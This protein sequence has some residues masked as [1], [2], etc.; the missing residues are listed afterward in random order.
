ML[1]STL[2][3][4]SAFFSFASAAIRFLTQDDESGSVFHLEQDPDKHYFLPGIPTREVDIIGQASDAHDRFGVATSIRVSSSPL[5]RQFLDAQFN[6]FKQIDDVWSDKFM[7]TLFIGFEKEVNAFFDDS[8]KEWLLENGVRNLYI[9]RGIEKPTFKKANDLA[10]REVSDVP[11]HGPWLIR[12]KRHNRNRIRAYPVYGLVEDDHDAF[13]TGVLPDPIHG[14]YVPTNFTLESNPGA[15]YIPVPSRLSAWSGADLPLAGLRFAVK[16]IFDVQGL[17]TGAGSAAYLQTYKKAETTAPSVQRL[18]DLGATLVGKTRTSQFAHGAQPWEYVDFEY[19]RNPR[20]DGYLT[21]GASSSGSACAIAAYDWIDFT[22]GSDT[23]GSIRKPAAL[24]GAFGLRPSHGTL[25]LDG[26]LP[27]SEEMDTIGFFTRDPMIFE[28]IGRNWYA[29]SDV[30]NRSPTIRLPKHLLYP[31][32]H[33]PLA[34]EDAQILI[35]KFKHL[36]RKHLN[37]VTKPMDM[38]ETLAPHFPSKSFEKFQ[39]VSNSLAEWR[40][41][42]DVGKPLFRAYAN[43]FGPENILDLELDPVPSKMFRKGKKLTQSD[44]VEALV[45][46][47]K[48]ATAMDEEVFLPNSKACADSLFMY[49]AGTGGKPSF[50]H[51]ELNE[52]EGATQFVLTS[53]PKGSTEGPKTEQFFHYVASMAGLPEATIPLGQ[54]QYKSPV[55]G[56]WEWMPVAVQI[57][58]RRGCDGVLYELIRKLGDKGIVKAV[59]AGAE[60]Y[61]RTSN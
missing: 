9:T 30:I 59:Q 36:L 39:Q 46:K 14:G 12:T 19:S 38:S 26:V 6:A 50:R 10:I 28:S 21:A 13:T 7:Q 32:E 2:L 1:L 17:Q 37:I 60:A 44:F 33:F 15:Y 55:T 5:S 34:N 25:D 61:S 43:K 58:T 49:D 40:S 27:L 57:V 29:N 18:I 35:E 41:W 54:V 45:V 56:N 52:F 8:G 23:R 53:P 51:E 24:V 3:S 42:H 47:N 22:V 20:G 16:D 4:V 48:F 31:T 11:P